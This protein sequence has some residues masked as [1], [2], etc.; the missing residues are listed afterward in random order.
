MFGEGLLC[1]SSAPSD[2]RVT[3]GLSTSPGV[4]WEVKSLGLVVHSDHGK[5]K[6]KICE[7]LGENKKYSHTDLMGL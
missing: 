3:P 5:L 7:I 6:S 4:D 2:F 1:L